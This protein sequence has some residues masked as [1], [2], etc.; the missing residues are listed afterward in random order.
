MPTTTRALSSA[1]GVVLPPV[2]ARHE[3][4]VFGNQVP[5]LAVQ[6]GLDPQ[7]GRRLVV[8]RRGLE[9]ETGQSVLPT[10]IE[11]EPLATRPLGGPAG[12]D[13]PV[14]GQA[15]VGLVARRRR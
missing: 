8:E 5:V 9:G 2:E 4:R 7:P 12:P 6:R 14:E 10:E 11:L 15:R 3:V 13:L 1:R